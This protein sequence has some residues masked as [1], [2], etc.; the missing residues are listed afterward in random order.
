MNSLSRIIKSSGVVEPKQPP[1]EVFAVVQSK[2]LG[3]T[4]IKSGATQA[5]WDSYKYVPPQIKKDQLQDDLNRIQVDLNSA[6]KELDHSTEELEKA[7]DELKQYLAQVQ[8]LQKKKRAIE[9]EISELKKID[10][11]KEA[12][13][14]INKANQEAAR[15]IEEAQDEAN[16]QAEQLK[17]Q[18]Y[19]DGLE[20]GASEARLQYQESRQPE[21]EKL[22]T[23]MSDL[24]GIREELITD[25]EKDITDIIMLMAEKVVAAELHI[26]PEAV[27]NMLRSVVEQNRTQEYIRVTISEDL[28]P[29]EAAVSERVKS[30]ILKLSHQLEI[31]V[32]SDGKAKS[33]TVETPQ[34]TTDMGIKTQLGNIEEAVRES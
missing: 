9:D 33:L 10:P 30:E 13:E 28:I 15:L 6:K 4:V 8:Q 23:L 11:T 26:Y 24:S 2:I 27:V 31:T 22:S 32:Q 21:I 20:Q 17:S 25:S 3:S 12:R 5:G 34:G 18:G 29:A 14:I 7:H 19:L 1:E 16:R